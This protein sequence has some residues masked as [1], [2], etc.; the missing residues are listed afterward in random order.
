MTPS[1]YTSLRMADT[2]RN[3]TEAEP[4]R[5]ST[6]HRRSDEPLRANDPAVLLRH[7]G[8]NRLRRGRRQ[9]TPSCIGLTFQA[10]RLSSSNTGS[11]RVGK[12]KI[13]CLAVVISFATGLLVGLGPLAHKAIQQRITESDR[14]QTWEDA[15]YKIRVRCTN[16]THNFRVWIEKGTMTADVQTVYDC[17]T[18]GA[19]LRLTGHVTEYSWDTALTDLTSPVPIARIR[20]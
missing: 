3:I 19:R 17:G 18:C 6:I 16:C 9:A 11:E 13:I 10:A 12:H 8:S 1:V 7:A 15:R 2:L 20:Q 5:P 4:R 14:K